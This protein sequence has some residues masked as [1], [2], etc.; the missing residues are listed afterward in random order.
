MSTTYVG[1]DTSL[2]RGANFPQLKHIIHNWPD[3]QAKI[4]LRRIRNVMSSK[5]RLLIRKDVVLQGL[6]ECKG[7]MLTVHFPR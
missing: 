2:S 7:S 5:S 1:H 3:S 4:I 6:C